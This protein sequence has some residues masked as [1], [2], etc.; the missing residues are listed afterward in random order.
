MNT[1]HLRLLPGILLLVLTACGEP[2]A[3]RAGPGDAP[4]AARLADLRRQVDDLRLRAGRIQDANDIKRLQRAF[5][6]YMDEALWD[7]V[8]ALFADD[9]T[10]EMAR[11]GIYRGKA[12]IREYF[13]ALGGGGQGLS[14]GQLNEH[15]QLMPVI[16]LAEDGM[17]ARGRWRALQ[18][19]GEYGEGAYWGEGPY[20]NEYVKED[21]VWKISKLQWFQTL[22]VPYEGGW[23]RHE[24][25]NRGIYV[26]EQLPPDAPPSHDFGW[27][28]ETFLPPFH[29][30]NP[31][32]RYQRGEETP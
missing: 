16:T 15:Y 26:S 7:E 8:V 18:L 25:V 27:W 32:G 13:F 19:T 2:P 28:P 6:Y 11:D 22:V 1:K 20:E 24:D 10:L 21:G 12:R 3:Q 17:S 4:E 31:V 5:G 23:A 29:F 30:D 9:A 14:E